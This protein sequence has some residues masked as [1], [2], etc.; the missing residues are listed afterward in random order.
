MPSIYL[1]SCLQDQTCTVISLH[2]ELDAKLQLVNLGFHRHSHIKVI[3]CRGDSLILNIDGSR[4]AIDR[5]LAKKIE[6]E[7]LSWPFL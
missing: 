4:F 5:E 1:D 7:L 2:G 3:L 6:V